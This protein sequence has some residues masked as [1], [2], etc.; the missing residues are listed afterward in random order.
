MNERFKTQVVGFHL[1]GNIFLL[2]NFHFSFIFLENEDSPFCLTAELLEKNIVESQKSG[3]KVKAF[4]YCNPHNPLGV[5]YPRHLTISLMQVCKKYKVHFI[6]DEIYGLSVFDPST[7]FDSVL[8]I[9]KDE[10]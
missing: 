2:L 4:I 3:Q 5:V 6:S 10:V 9:P 1:E 7:S 8:S